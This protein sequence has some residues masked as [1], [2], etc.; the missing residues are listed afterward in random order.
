MRKFIL[1]ALALVACA[2]TNTT[3]PASTTTPDFA[4]TSER[5]KQIA[6]KLRGKFADIDAAGLD[7]LVLVQ[8][9]AQVPLADQQLAIDAVANGAYFIPD[10]NVGPELKAL[11]S[12]QFKVKP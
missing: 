2:D 1:A 12:K 10:G 5:G 6:D 9:I 3:P 4:V 8:L 11:M 7:T